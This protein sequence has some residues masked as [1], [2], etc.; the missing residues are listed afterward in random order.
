MRI[1]FI[2]PC[3]YDEDYGG[4]Q[5]TA[6]LAFEA[7]RNNSAPLG[8]RVLC[9]GPKCS[10]A[11]RNSVQVCSHSKA[12]AA[13]RSLSLRRG[14][15]PLVFWHVDL[16][17]L[18]PLIGARAG[19]IFL[20]LH[21]I[22]CWR[23]FNQPNH[24]LLDRIDVFLTN[25]DF[26][27]RRFIEM[28]PRYREKAHRTV[29]L[30]VGTPEEEVDAPGTT[31]AAVIVGRMYRSE[32]YKGHA[33]LLAAW[34]LVLERI[35][36]AELWVVGGG[37]GVDRIRQHASD[38]GIGKQVHF[39][40]AIPEEEKQR[41]LR[42]SHCLVLPSRYEGF[43]LVYL[44]AMRLGRPCLSGIHDAGQE[45]VRPPD[46]GLAVD[47]ADTRNLAAAIATLLTPGR[48]WQLQSGNARRRYE[49]NFTASHFQRRL[50]NAVL[51][52]IA[53]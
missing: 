40:G 19:K 8:T 43:G 41:L 26:T 28:N 25:S 49:E 21:G 13:F 50:L 42:R 36:D 15:G 17:K 35:P 32:S 3:F 4:V 47:P 10:H 12:E 14:A 53:V 33:E 11:V 18:L 9:Y 22:E 5:L 39:F 6:S 31:P 37:D 46:A 48:A 29:H 38:I 27:W 24:R 1:D 45:V 7:F 51:E 20:F 52:D 34:P 16:L 23:H 44:E 30:G 2:S